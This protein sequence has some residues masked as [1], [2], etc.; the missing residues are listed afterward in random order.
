MEAE[1]A[2]AAMDTREDE[3]SESVDIAVDAQSEASEATTVRPSLW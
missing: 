1:D 2:A 3:D